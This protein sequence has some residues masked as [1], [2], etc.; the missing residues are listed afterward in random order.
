[1]RK[2]ASNAPTFVSKWLPRFKAIS[3]FYTVRFL[4]GIKVMGAIIPITEKPAP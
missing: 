4:A 3:A 1:V 2:P